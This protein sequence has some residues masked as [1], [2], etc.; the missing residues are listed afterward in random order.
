MSKAAKGVSLDVER[1]TLARIGQELEPL[2]IL[3]VRELQVKHQELFGDLPKTKNT[4]FLRKK[5]AW[6]IQEL[7]EGG[8]SGPVQERIM[9]LAPKE[10][11]VRRPKPLESNPAA[12]RTKSRP[13]GSTRDP[14]LPDIGTTL[15]RDYQGTQHKVQVMAEGFRHQGKLYPSLSSVAKAITGTPWNGYLFFGLIN[16]KASDGE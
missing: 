10:L 11:P 3:G 15:Q 6:R 9:K 14:R 12:S 1:T 8:L 7:I 13:K 2:K 16:R 4:G 5:L